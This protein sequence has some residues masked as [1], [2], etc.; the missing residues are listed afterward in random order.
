MLD[1]A[2]VAAGNLFRQ[3]H[4]EQGG[5]AWLKASGTS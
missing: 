5:E 1:Q 2:L 4:D 3:L